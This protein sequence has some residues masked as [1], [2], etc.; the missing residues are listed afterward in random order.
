MHVSVQKE[1]LYAWSQ[2]PSWA[3]CVYLVQGIVWSQVPSGVNM[4][5]TLLEATTPLVGTPS[6]KVHPPIALDVT[7]PYWYSPQEGTPLV[8]TSSGYH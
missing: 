5:G 8:V 6:W 7:P 4:P 3:G 1:G 2:V